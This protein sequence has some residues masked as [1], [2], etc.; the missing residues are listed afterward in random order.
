MTLI[1]KAKQTKN[2]TDIYGKKNVGSRI[3]R[4]EKK[5]IVTGKNKSKG[6]NR[7]TQNRNGVEL[8]MW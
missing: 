2:N 3:T 6:Y 7:E 5:Q 1:S 8:D 4:Y